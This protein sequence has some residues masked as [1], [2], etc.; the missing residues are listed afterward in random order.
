VELNLK[1]SNSP[2][3]VSLSMPSKNNEDQL[4]IENVE[5]AKNT[6]FE[7]LSMLSQNGL[8]K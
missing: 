5:N 3:K 2:S 4:T 8:D 7:V 6:D 1:T